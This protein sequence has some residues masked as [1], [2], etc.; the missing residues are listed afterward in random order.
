MARLGHRAAAIGI[1]LTGAKR[2]CRDSAR[3]AGFD[4]YR[5][6]RVCWA[7]GFRSSIRRKAAQKLKERL[8]N[9]TLFDSVIRCPVSAINLGDCNL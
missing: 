8:E 2:T 9:L 5:K 3:T 1:P 7:A 4:P 6:S